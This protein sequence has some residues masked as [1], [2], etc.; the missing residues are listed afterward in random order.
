MLLELDGAGAHEED[1]WS[2][3]R[4]RVGGSVVR[5]AGPVGRCAV[6]TQDPDTGAVTLDTLRGIRRY[7]GSREGEIDFGVYF[8]V[9]EPGRI[10]VGDALELL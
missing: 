3:R 2:D 5:V 1:S 6:T 4:A 10:R 7:R 9:E 8:D